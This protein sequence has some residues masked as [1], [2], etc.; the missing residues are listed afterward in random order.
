[1]NSDL[2]TLLLAVSPTLTFLEISYCKIERSNTYEEHAIDAAVSRM[3]KLNRLRLTGD[4]STALSI[5]RGA[6]RQYPGSRITA[7]L[8]SI[9]ICEAPALDCQSLRK[10]LET[11]GWASV[12]VQGDAMKTAG[13]SLRQE[14]RDI[15]LARGIVLIRRDGDLHTN[16]NPTR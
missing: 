1:M 12:T 15:A 3:V 10:A 9:S 2:L 11:T 4:C 13:D 14:L 5:A 7:P 6:P 8:P 16:V